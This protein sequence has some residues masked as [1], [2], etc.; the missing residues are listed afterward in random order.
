MKILVDI[1]HPAHVHF[2]KL[3]MLMWRDAGHEIIVTSR[4]K[5]IATELLDAVG[6]R[7][8]VLSSMNDGTKLGMVKELVRRD[9]GL[10]R[11]VLREKPDIM[12]GIG[13]IFIAHTGFL[14]RT[15]SITFYDTENASFSNLITY[16]FTSLVVVPE[17]YKAW[18]PP[19]KL[20]YP[21]YHELSYLHPDV[22]RPDKN[23]AMQCGLEPEKPTY[24]LR[25]VSWHASH[26]L[27]ELGWTIEL[28][29]KVIGYLQKTGKV[30]ISSEKKLPNDLESLK[31]VG[32]PEKIH[33]LMGHI[34][35]FVGESATMASEC[36]VMGVPAIYA[37][38]T[39]RGYTD[40][41]EHKYELVCNLNVLRWKDLKELIRMCLE[42]EEEAWG[43]RQKKMLAE[44]T[45]VSRFISE[46]VVDYPN[47]LQKYRD[48]FSDLGAS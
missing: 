23:I 42:V 44:K 7:H 4:K 14:T 28:L 39:G 16:P 27:H 19:W 13:G 24:L 26:D 11:V 38:E 22:F 8:I 3:P 33:H 31:Y 48:Q 20:R 46:L 37:A 10:L 30:I 45:V 36:A 18:L 43:L 15:P 25:V 32:P 9:Y 41:L 1:G 35:L 40:E 17:C 12:A 34:R 47:S 2:F 29:E 21:G 5:E 6:V